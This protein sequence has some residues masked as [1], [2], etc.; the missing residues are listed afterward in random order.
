MKMVCPQ[1][2]TENAPRVTQ[3]MAK[4]VVILKPELIPSPVFPVP[5]PVGEVLVCDP[6]EPEVGFGVG[7]VPV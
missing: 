4:R 6:P 2:N 1:V 7:T 3:P 5:V